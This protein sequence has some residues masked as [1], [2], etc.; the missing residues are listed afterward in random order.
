M[1]AVQLTRGVGDA[2]C[3]SHGPLHVRILILV[4]SFPP[5]LP[6]WLLPPPA[7][8]SRTQRPAVHVCAGMLPCPG[9]APRQAQAPA[10][11]PQLALE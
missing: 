2:G 7:P 5:L 10:A 8:D 9:P 6:W 11:P 1:A 3:G 4:R